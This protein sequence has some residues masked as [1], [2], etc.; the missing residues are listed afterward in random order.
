MKEQP[1]LY[2][3]GNDEDHYAFQSAD[4]TVQVSRNHE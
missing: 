4:L 3:G 2:I 1:T